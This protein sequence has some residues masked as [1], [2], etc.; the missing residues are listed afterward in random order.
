MPHAALAYAPSE[1]SVLSSAV[2][3]WA[4]EGSVSPARAMHHVARRNMWVQKM[5]LGWNVLADTDISAGVMR[6]LPAATDGP[7]WRRPGYGTRCRG[8]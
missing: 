1:A 8:A 6:S 5:E 4:L 2:V 7:L 3:G